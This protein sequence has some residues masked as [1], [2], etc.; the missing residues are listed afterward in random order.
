MYEK[1]K[2]GFQKH[3]RGSTLFWNLK[4]LYCPGGWVGGHQ[5]G[6]STFLI[7]KSVD[8]QDALLL[9]LASKVVYDNYIKSYEQL[10][11]ENLKFYGQFPRRKSAKINDG[12]KRPLLEAQIE[13]FFQ[14]FFSK[15]CDFMFKN[16]KKTE[17][18]KMVSKRL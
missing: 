14:F 13:K 18:S 7:F 4:N 12:Q 6:P 2:W 1:R 11:F 5:K 3:E 16:M 8:K 15:K 9:N 10:K 17:S